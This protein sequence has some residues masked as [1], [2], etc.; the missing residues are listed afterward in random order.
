MD[1]KK[2]I[3]SLMILVRLSVKYVKKFVK[4]VEY[5]IFSVELSIFLF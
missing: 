5:N 2:N 3:E 1:K 4:S